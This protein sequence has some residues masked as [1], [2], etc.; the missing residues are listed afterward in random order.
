MFLERFAVFTLRLRAKLLDFYNYLLRETDSQLGQI[1]FTCCLI[2]LTGLLF[3]IWITPYSL[4][5]KFSFT[6]I[7]L[8]SAL[9]CISAIY[10][11][12]TRKRIRKR[13]DTLEVY[14]VNNPEIAKIKQL[15][16]K[17]IPLTL[18]QTNAVF[19][20]FSRKYLTG[21][22]QTFQSLIL[23]EPVPARSRLKW[24]DL[25]PKRPKQV[26]RQTLLEFLSHLLIGFENLDNHQMI[27]FVEH[28]FILK[29]TAGTEQHLSSKNISDWRNNKSSYLKEISSIF[30]AIL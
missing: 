28:Y 8:L 13:S 25:S 27:L 1:F 9:F 19:K 17:P 4:W 14:T 7:Y 12:L 2:L 29:N 26:N 23:M 10:F 5:F 15:N 24:Q 6:V 30:K 22:Y 20:A 11:I 21:D 16:L 3:Y 18:G